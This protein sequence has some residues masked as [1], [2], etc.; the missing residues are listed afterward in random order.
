MASEK[1]KISMWL[2]EFADRD[3]EAAFQSHMQ[4]IM[5]RQLQIVLIVW[6]ILLALFAIP[7]LIVLGLVPP[8]YYLLTFRVV[9]L[10]AISILFLM[11]RPET[12][13]FKISYPYTLV[14]IAYTTGFMMFFIY[15]S[16]SLDLVMGVVALQLMSLLMFVPIRFVML[17]YTALYTVIITLGARFVA[18]TP[19]IRLLAIFVL[20]MLPVVVG[21]VTAIRLAILH[22]KQF[23]LLRET[24]K[25]NV[26][27]QKA[28][29]DKKELSGLLP[30]CAS[31]KNIRNDDGYWE[32]I[33]GYIKEHSKAE[34]S[35]GICPKCMEKL[36]GEEDW[37]KETKIKD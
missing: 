22:R 26:E 25:I 37:Y 11:I 34:F 17:F 5:I 21:A 20:L 6:G 10:V 1:Y 13:I 7:D 14:T 16:D 2:A 33:E 29:S 36:Y 32:Q 24:E 3:M 31:C 28:L 4:P 18:G 8:F 23:R 9:S 15:R 12:N 35:H 27:L 19:K 30:I